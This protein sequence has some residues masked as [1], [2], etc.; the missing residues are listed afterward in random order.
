VLDGSIDVLRRDGLD[1]ETPVTTHRAGQLRGKSARLTA[2]RRSP[3]RE[4]VVTALPCFRS[5]RRI[6]EP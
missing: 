2:V 3:R 1:E 5:I 4:P 6:C